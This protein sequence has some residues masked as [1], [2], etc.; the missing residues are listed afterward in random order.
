MQQQG[1]IYKISKFLNI[2]S[3]FYNTPVKQKLAVQHNLENM[4]QD[5]GD[6]AK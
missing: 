6:I 5:Y 1:S 2:W 3:L 4:A